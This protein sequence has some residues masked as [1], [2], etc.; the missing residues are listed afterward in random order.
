MH[1]LDVL[2][3][4][5]RRRILEVLRDGESAAGDLV[6]VLGRE[7][8]ISQP[9]VSQQLRVLREAGFVRVR[10]EAQRR[11]YTIEPAPLREANDWIARFQAFWERRFDALETEIA[12]G[13]RQ[14]RRQPVVSAASGART[15]RG[16]R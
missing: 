15:A 6:D 13:K 4:P 14:R 11:L 2:G 16:R 7:L 9:A 5:T 12:R 10:A 1:A 3:D 8:G